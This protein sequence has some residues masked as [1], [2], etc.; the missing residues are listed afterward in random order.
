M[1]KLNDDNVAQLMM[2]LAESFCEHIVVFAETAKQSGASEEDYSA[3]VYAT[4]TA[5][6]AGFETEMNPE[7]LG[8]V[9]ELI[10]QAD[11]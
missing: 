1:T 10:K 6:V 5:L 2:K 9:K 3:A 4:L 8:S 7:V 11:A